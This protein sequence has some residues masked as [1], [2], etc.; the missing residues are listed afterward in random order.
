MIFKSPLQTI[1]WFYNLAHILFWL[2]YLHYK[3]K[4]QNKAKNPHQDKDSGMEVRHGHKN[5]QRLDIV[6]KLCARWDIKSQRRNDSLWLPWWLPAEQ[7]AFPALQTQPYAR[8][9][10]ALAHSGLRRLR[11]PWVPKSWQSLRYCLEWWNPFNHPL[12]SGTCPKE[13]GAFGLD[14]FKHPAWQS[15]AKLQIA[16]VVPSL[17]CKQLQ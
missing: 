16:Q 3:K 14:S 15:D 6:P 11:H 10:V 7:E 4:K 1:L 13:E 9:N 17:F 8:R 5:G 2:L 12:F